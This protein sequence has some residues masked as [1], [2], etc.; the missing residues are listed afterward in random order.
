[1]PEGVFLYYIPG[2]KYDDV[3]PSDLAANPV[4]A[5]PFFD[6]I[7]SP[8]MFKANRVGVTVENRGPD[9]GAGCIVSVQPQ[10]DR[11]LNTPHYNANT[12]TWRKFGEQ[13]IGWQEDMKPGP[14]SLRRPKQ[15][16]GYEV[17]LGDG[18]IWIA[19]TVRPFHE[20]QATLGCSLPMMLGIDESREHTARVVERFRDIWE[21]TV[22]IADIFYNGE[23]YAQF[24]FFDDAVKCL[25]LNYRIGNAEATILELLN[26]EL[27]ETVCGASVDGPLVEKFLEARRSENPTEAPAPASS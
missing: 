21:T 12:Q 4:L 22:R 10:V 8:K 1:M 7:H 5:G 6:L 23:Q 26:T 27:V 18:K 3:Q 16:D 9:N 15:I 11:N 24:A 20:T 2:K 13:W 25:A 14:E 19:P 17:E